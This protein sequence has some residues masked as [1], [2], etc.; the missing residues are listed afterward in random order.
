MNNP[1]VKYAIAVFVVLAV[2]EFAPEAVNVILVLILVGMLLISAP[3][4]VSL[5]RTIGSVGK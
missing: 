3:S 5:A 4:F 2:A 1:I